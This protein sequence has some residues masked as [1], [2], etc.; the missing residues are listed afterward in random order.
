[1]LLLCRLQSAAADPHGLEGRFPPSR[2][3]RT[4]GPAAVSPAV[5]S[6]CVAGGAPTQAFDL[7]QQY[8][9]VISV[10]A[11][12]ACLCSPPGDAPGALA[13]QEC[14]GPGAPLHAREIGWNFTGAGAIPKAGTGL[15]ATAAVAAGGA[16]MLAPCQPGASQEWSYDVTTQSVSSGSLCLTAAPAPLPLLSNV[17]G[18]NMV[19]QRDV[20]AEVWGWTAPGGTVVVSF[21]GANTTSAPTGTDGRWSVALPPTAAGEGFTITTIDVGSGKSAVLLNVAFGDVVWCS[22]QSNLSGHNTPVRYAFNATAEIAAAAAYPW[23]RVFAVGVASQGSPAPLPQLGY[24]PYIPWSVA[25]PSSV[26]L[27]SATCWFHGKAIADALGPTVPIGLIES[28]WGGTSI[29]VW[30]P[31]GIVSACGD[32]PAYPGGWPVATSSLWNSMTAPFAGMRVSGIV[33]YQGESNSITAVFEDVYYTCALPFLVASLREAFLTP[34]AYAAIVQLAPWASTAASFNGQV[35]TLREAQ[36]VACDQLPNMTAITAV[37]G[38]DPFGPIGSIHPR[39]KQLVGRRL[40]GVALTH[41]YGVPTPFAGPRY[42]S[43]VAGS[44]GSLSATVSFAPPSSASPGND[45]AMQLLT[46]SPVG[47]H[48]NSSVCPVGVTADLCSSFALRG[49]DGVWYAATATLDQSSRT[50]LLLAA[51]AGD[52]LTATATASGWSLWPISLLYSSAGLPAWPWN[53]SIA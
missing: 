24:D 44:P 31:A 21:A 22:G 50:L 39:A 27:F 25:A 30:E 38:G 37:D 46:P 16:V 5:I 14:D 12:G 15:C 33:W 10:P 4:R 17:F 2:R 40:A 35:A 32:P 19:L 28:A 29:Q 51:G 20:P 13:F 7:T 43:A 48:A 1:V 11:L 34:A 47:P 52:K 53:A 8:G 3:A 23:V 36:L 18:S 26:A 42:A 49:S 6:A 41:L 45:G 9:G